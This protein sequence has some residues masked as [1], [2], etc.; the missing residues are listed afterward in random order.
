MTW[1]KLCLVI[2]GM[3]L[4]LVESG[5]WHAGFQPGHILNVAIAALLV[6]TSLRL[7]EL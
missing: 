6:W 7:E 4:G 3:Q 5:I 1:S 2:A